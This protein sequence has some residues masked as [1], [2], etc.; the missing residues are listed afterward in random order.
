MIQTL[1]ERKIYWLW[2]TQKLFFIL[3]DDDA[4]TNVERIA[5]DAIDDCDKKLSKGLSTEVRVS[6]IDSFCIAE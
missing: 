4:T 3:Y 1:L 5:L 6:L 2:T